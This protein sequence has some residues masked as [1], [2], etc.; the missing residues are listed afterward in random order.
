MLV[1]VACRMSIEDSHMQPMGKSMV[2]RGCMQRSLWKVG[3]IL[4]NGKLWAFV[5]LSA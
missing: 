5:T 3:A 1:E 2:A 4:V